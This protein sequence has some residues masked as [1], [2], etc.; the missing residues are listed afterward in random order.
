[1][2]SEPLEGIWVNPNLRGTQLGLRC[3]SQS[4]RTLLAKTKSLCGLVN[5]KNVSAQKMYQRAGFKLRSTYDT[6]FV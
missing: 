6:I 3:I 2:P 4:A 1:V 5:K